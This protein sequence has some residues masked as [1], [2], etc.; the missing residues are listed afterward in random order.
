MRY[1]KQT[2][3]QSTQHSTAFSARLKACLGL[4]RGGGK[5]HSTPTEC[6]SQ[7]SHQQ[8]DYG[9]ELVHSHACEVSRCLARQIPHHLPRYSSIAVPCLPPPVPSWNSIAI[10]SCSS[11]LSSHLHPRL[12]LNFHIVQTTYRSC[13]DLL[14]GCRLSPVAYR[15]SRPAAASHCRARISLPGETR[16][17]DKRV[18]T[19]DHIKTTLSA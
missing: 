1:D 19:S 9:G 12:S 14:L 18:T 15:L 3:A 6:K 5:R 13:P 10:L 2:Q 8:A 16:E 7:F 17:G 11:G 4:G